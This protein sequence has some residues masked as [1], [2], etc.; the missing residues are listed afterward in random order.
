MVLYA[1]FQFGSE[2]N[3]LEEKEKEQCSLVNCLHWT[4]VKNFFES[5]EMRYLLPH[6]LDQAQIPLLWI[7]IIPI[8]SKVLYHKRCNYLC[9]NQRQQKQ[10]QKRPRDADPPEL[11]PATNPLD[12]PSPVTYSYS[13]CLLNTVMQLVSTFVTVIICS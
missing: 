13:F 2:Y 7:M 5:S 9:L 6:L 11:P 4:A 3:F 8:H 10:H 12:K 1:P